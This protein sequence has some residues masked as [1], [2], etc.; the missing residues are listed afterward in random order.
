MT[1]SEQ[2][3]A[4]K[5][6]E[7]LRRYVDMEDRFLSHNRPWLLQ[8]EEVIAGTLYAEARKLLELPIL[9]LK[10]ASDSDDH[11]HCPTCICGRRA[12]VQGDDTHG[13]GSISYREHLQAHSGYTARFGSGCQST[14]RLAAPSGF[15][16]SELLMFLGHE[17]KTWQPEIK[18]D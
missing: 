8:P 4:S 7:L 11:Q 5:A 14:E 17:P 6:L 1:V 16:Y 10:P 9:E 15:S 13:S 18:E 2:D 3:Q 12:P